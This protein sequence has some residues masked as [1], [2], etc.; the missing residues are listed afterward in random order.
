MKTYNIKTEIRSALR[1]VWLYSPLRRDALKRSKI[2]WG[3][4]VCP[5]CLSI[6]GPKLMDVDHIVKATPK[7]GINEPED[8]G[9]FIKNL[10][11]CGPDG[12]VALCKPCHAIKTK[13][14]RS[15]TK[16][17]TKSKRLRISRTKRAHKG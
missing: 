9:I 1:R 3:K 2:A 8:W 17:K 13:E 7:G 11:Y 4:Y 6:N 16:R 12:V 14:E 5:K 15:E 10:L